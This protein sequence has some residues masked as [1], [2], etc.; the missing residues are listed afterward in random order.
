MLTESIFSATA[1][2]S[3]PAASPD[4]HEVVDR[5]DKWRCSHD[6]LYRLFTGNDTVELCSFVSGL[7]GG[8]EVPDAPGLLQARYGGDLNANSR[9][10]LL[11]LRNWITWTITEQDT[12]VCSDTRVACHFVLLVALVLEH[13]FVNYIVLAVNDRDSLRAYITQFLAPALASFLQG[14]IVKPVYPG[15]S[16]AF[17]LL[18]FVDN[19]R[20][21]YVIRCKPT[22]HAHQMP[23]K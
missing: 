12:S 14:V 15:V 21:Q 6:V 1:P 11:M 22:I 10:M 7:V 4:I 23:S 18:T 8:G 9:E 13:E 16:C 5:V 20:S 3:T 17:D 19:C 2:A